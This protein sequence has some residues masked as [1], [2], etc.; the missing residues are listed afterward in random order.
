MILA[1][2]FG[3]ECKNPGTV[4]WLKSGQPLCVTADGDTSI[5]GGIIFADFPANLLG[6]FIMGFMQNGG[7][8]DLP[9]ALPIAWL[10]ENH[11]FQS[12]FTIHFAIMTGFC[13]SL[14]T[15]SSWNSEMVM[16]LLGEDADKG[17]LIFRA[18]FGY[19][20]GVETCMASFILGKNVAKYIFSY[21]NPALH[22]ESIES[23]R[24]KQYGIYINTELSDFERRF[25]SGFNMGEHEIKIDPEVA[26]QLERW[27]VST[28]SCRRH[29]HPLLPLLTDVEYQ[30]MVL[31]EPLR[32]DQIVSSIEAEWNIEALENWVY[33]KRNFAQLSGSNI[34]SP[35][36]FKFCPA[37]FSFF[38]LFC[39]LFF[40]LAFMDSNEAYEV[41]YRTMIFAALLAPTGAILRWRLCKLN[42]TIQR[43]N[44][45]PVGTLAANVIGSIFSASMIGLESRLNGFQSFWPI[46]TA[47]A[48]KIGFSGSLSTVSTYVA[49][50]SALL[51]SPHPFRG[52]MY[53]MISI[54]ISA[55]LAGVSFTI[56]HV[57]LDNNYY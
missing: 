5:S 33:A 17:S 37:A 14:T 1:Q 23:E 26:E 9:K 47:R 20:I 43:Y 40:T 3:E 18:L 51:K 4:G 21:V 49:E 38:V 22:V 44:W 31:D 48:L 11:P 29:G 12:D 52:Y 55:V 16:M 27:R 57:D 10:N 42:G 13:G 34:V 28:E 24:I 36:D 19:F 54:V 56:I 8:M 53:I 45:F 32:R 25:L 7:T 15:F 6:S 2:L 39:A 41:T 30:T 46:G 50:A 35:R